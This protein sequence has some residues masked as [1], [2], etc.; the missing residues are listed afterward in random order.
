[1]NHSPNS[2]DVPAGLPNTL[3]SAIV[4]RDAWLAFVEV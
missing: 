1:M 4:G 2:F 3:R